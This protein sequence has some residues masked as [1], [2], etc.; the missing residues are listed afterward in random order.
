MPDRPVPLTV[1]DT[2]VWIWVVEGD[3][4]ALAASAIEAIERAAREGA[5]RVS[6]ISVWEVAMLE[7]KGRIS[8]SRPVDDWVQ[9]ALRAPGVRLL[10]LSP[11]IA[12]ESTRLPGAP[13][14]DRADRILMACA[15]HLGGRLATCDGEILNYSEGGRL[16]VLNCM[17]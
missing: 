17:P 11:E 10:P 1:L 3:R 8:V 9:A 6:A 16:N 14:G 7:A 15:R 4:T 13:H 2:H 12:I 5:L